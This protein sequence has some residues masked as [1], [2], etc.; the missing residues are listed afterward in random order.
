[1]HDNRTLPRVFEL[2][3]DVMPGTETNLVVTKNEVI[4]EDHIHLS[5]KLV[6]TLSHY[7]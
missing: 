4:Y 3:V 1:M 2:G 5:P 6:L 7:T